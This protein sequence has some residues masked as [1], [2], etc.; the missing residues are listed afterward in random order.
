MTKKTAIL[1]PAF[2]AILILSSC[3]GKKAADY[4][5]QIRAIQQDTSMFA[6]PKILHEIQDCYYLYNESGKNADEMNMRIVYFG[7]KGEGTLYVF[8][9]ERKKDVRETPIKYSSS[10]DEDNSLSFYTKRGAYHLLVEEWT[11]PIADVV[12]PASIRVMSVNT[13]A[14][15]YGKMIT[16]ERAMK[17]IHGK[18]EVAQQ[19]KKSSEEDLYDP[20]LK[21]PQQHTGIDKEKLNEMKQEPCKSCRGSGQCFMCHGIGKTGNDYCHNCGGSGTC[22]SCGGSGVTM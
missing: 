18:P 8:D 4:E 14:G 20:D 12:F 11:E 9:P 6:A 16:K 15:A 13:N 7:E 21:M 5:A 10:L 19:K 17:I 3:N 22:P 2:A 1:M